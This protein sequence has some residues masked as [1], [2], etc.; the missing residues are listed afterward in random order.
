LQEEAPMHIGISVE[1]AATD[2]SLQKI[3][4]ECRCLKV[5]NGI[6]FPCPQNLRAAHKVG[7]KLRILGKSGVTLPPTRFAYRNANPVANKSER[8]AHTLDNEP[9]VLKGHGFI[10]AA[11]G[12][13]SAGL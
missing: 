5:R 2:I 9:L 7:R 1:S 4:R 11:M 13:E 8:P 12:L 3:F 6:A 10:R